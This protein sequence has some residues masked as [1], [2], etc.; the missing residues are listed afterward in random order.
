MYDSHTHTINSPDARQTAEEICLAALDMGMKGFAVTEHTHV[1]PVYQH[2][3][4][5]FDPIKA[6]KGSVRDLVAIKEKYGDSLHIGC[7]L[8]VDEYL[9]DPKANDILMS[10]H[11]F[12]VILGSI[13]YLKD[14]GWDLQYSK[15][16]YGDSVSDQMIL[17]YLKKYFEAIALMTEKTD[18]DVLAHLT[19]PMRYI[20]GRHKRTVDISCFDPIIK[21][22]LKT[23]ISRKIALEVNTTGL[24][25]EEF[26]RVLCPDE[27]VLKTY[28]ALG[29]D[30][31]TLGSDAHRREGLA[32]G[33]SEAKTILKDLGFTR[34]HYYENRYP[35]PIDIE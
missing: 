33:F 29:G 18:M 9:D 5:G 32:K 30:L 22:I 19:C 3:F 24:L 12:D 34:Y 27:S 6:V 21:D 26:G 4:P 8:E 10:Y 2:Y 1:S 25:S 28:K 23:L 17:D 7:G 15:I 11:S 31:L 35:Y 13:H 14:G 20:N 16:V